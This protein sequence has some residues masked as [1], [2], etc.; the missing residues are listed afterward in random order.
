MALP[1][2]TIID[3]PIIELDTIDSTNNYAMQLIDAD[4]AQPGMTILAQLQTAGKGQRGRTWMD[5][6]GQ[7]LLMSIITLPLYGMDEQFLFNASVITGIADVLQAWN[8][9]CDV[10]I[11]WPNDIMVNDK[12][13]GGVLIENVL[14]GNTWAYSVIG[15]GINVLQSR[16]DESLPY[17]T[18]LKIASGEEHNLRGLA[19]ALR[20]GI[21]K[22]LYQKIPAADIMKRYNSHLYR[23]GMEQR[24]FDDRGEWAA[25]IVDAAPNGQLM[26]QTAD[27][28]ITAYTHGVVNWKWE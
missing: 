25:I 10:R 20:A 5:S 14:R 3:A 19:Q 4:T 26:V 27:G 16:L 21:L 23:K 9:N 24:F 17:A 8:E 12:K 6:P 2:Q 18:S 1:L 7:S 11:K 15:I 13:A 28:N 22:N